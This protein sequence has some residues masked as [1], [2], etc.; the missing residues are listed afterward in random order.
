[1]YAIF[2]PFHL[3]ST[4]NNQPNLRLPDTD[5]SVLC[6]PIYRR[7]GN[8][9]GGQGDRPIDTVVFLTRWSDITYTGPLNTWLASYAFFCLVKIC[10]YS[11]YIR[12]VCMSGDLTLECNQNVYSMYA[13]YLVMQFS[14]YSAA[15]KLPNLRRTHKPVRHTFHHFQQAPAAGLQICSCN[16][17]NIYKSFFTLSTNTVNIRVNW[18]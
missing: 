18:K 8:E 11:M 3:Y 12:T 10:M 1:M 6:S 2:A 17:Y 9:I 5:H 13:T 7:H 15:I 14:L 16:K 4:V